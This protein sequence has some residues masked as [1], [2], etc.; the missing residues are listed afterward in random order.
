MIES[1]NIGAE[2]SRE[3][4][5]QL[6]AVLG[7]TLRNRIGGGRT[8]AGN[9]CDRTPAD[10]AVRHGGDGKELRPEAEAMAADL[11]RAGGVDRR[12]G[13]V[14]G[15]GVRHGL[16]RLA[17]LHLV[18]QMAANKLSVGW[19]DGLAEIGQCHPVDAHGNASLLDCEIWNAFVEFTPAISRAFA[20][21]PDRA[22]PATVANVAAI[23]PDR[24]PLTVL[25]L[26]DK[27]HGVRQLKKTMPLE[28]CVFDTKAE[29]GPAQCDRRDQR[30]ANDILDGPRQTGSNQHG[31]RLRDKVNM[32][33]GIVHGLHRRVRLARRRSV[34][35]VERSHEIHIE[36]QAI[37]LNELKRIPRLRPNIDADDIEART[38]IAHACTTSAAEE[39][40]KT[41]TRHYAAALAGLVG[42]EDHSIQSFGVTAPS[43]AAL[44][45]DCA[46]KDGIL[47][48]RA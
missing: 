34:D 21:D 9:G 18:D 3:G 20:I 23:D 24:I 45:A 26:R 30:C 27:N 8:I 36:A 6:G 48:P 43:V 41:R 42:R 32:L 12:G 47:S 13:Q 4:D 40:E 39:V 19:R 14:I 38:M 5:T 16:G 25:A 46:L 15:E 1:G 17:L 7:A 37:G 22:R 29:H 35:R 2:L 28:V 10:A 31:A 11:D 44:I 33:A